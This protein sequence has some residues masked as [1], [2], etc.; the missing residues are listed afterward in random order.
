MYA[1]KRTSGYVAKSKL[2]D[3]STASVRSKSVKSGVSRRSH[4]NRRKPTK[5]FNEEL[6]VLSRKSKVS[7]QFSRAS[8][9]NE[10]NKR[11]DLN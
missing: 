4:L 9:K 10:D 3:P 7:N 5:R 8:V 2:K 1:P 6:D 11:K